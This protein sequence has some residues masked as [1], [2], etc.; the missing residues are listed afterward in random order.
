M[1][2]DRVAADAL[3]SYVQDIM[4]AHGADE[5]QVLCVSENM[6]WNN[7]VNRRNYGV[8]RLPIQMKRLRLGL[9]RAPCHPT[10]E[11]ASPSMER[12]DGDAGFGQ[13]VAELGMRR[14]IA[15]ARE[16]GVGIVAV[17]NSNYFGTGAYMVHLAAAAGMAGIV[18]SNAFPKVVPHGGIKP[19]F[20]TNPLAF[21][22][23]RRDG[24]SLLFDMATAALAG[25]KVRDHLR[26]GK[27]LPEGLAINTEG[28]PITD[29]ARVG[30][31]ALL[32]LGGAKGYGLAL[33]VEILSGVITGAG[34]SFGVAS[35]FG[36]FTR[37]ADIGHFLMALDISRLMPLAT[38]FER[39]DQLEQILADSA[40]DGQVRLPGMVRWQYYGDYLANGIPLDRQARSDLEELSSPY[41]IATPW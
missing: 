30:E 11:P 40:P 6:I 5:E 9:L 18:M 4:R 2:N 1:D 34:V 33:M 38:Y 10:F 26:T 19:V 8:R 16:A 37:S 13:Y 39:L 35:M 23:P 3:R 24:K 20:G 36:D 17:R 41:A 25:S 15:L 27:P 14:A 12:L 32:P 28:K 7:L 31:G 21:G 29:P 22:V